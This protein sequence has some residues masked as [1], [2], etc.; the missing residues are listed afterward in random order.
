MGGRLALR[1]G[2]L[3]R[4]DFLALVAAA[5]GGALAPPSP[6]AFPVKPAPLRPI[7]LERA[8]TVIDLPGDPILVRRAGVSAP[9]DFPVS[10]PTRLDPKAPK[11]DSAAFYV[12]SALLSADSGA[13]V[14]F[15]EA[16]QEANVLA[17]Q[18]AANAAALSGGAS[19]DSGATD[20]DGGAETPLQPEEASPSPA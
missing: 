4:V 19:L 6:V 11:V 15:S 17:F 1:G 3:R 2:G 9:K 16:G 14:K 20:D 13:M 10:L 5:S 7:G 12:A 18:I 8:S